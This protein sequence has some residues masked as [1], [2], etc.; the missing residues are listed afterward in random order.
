[1]QADK[2]SQMMQEIAARGQVDIVKDSVKASNQVA[3]NQ[4]QQQ[5]K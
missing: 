1:M 3:V 4:A 5:Q 2:G